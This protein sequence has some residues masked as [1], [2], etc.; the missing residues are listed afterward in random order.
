MA[1]LLT[2]LNAEGRLPS[3]SSLSSLSPHR[4]D[5]QDIYQSGPPH[6]YPNIGSALA[7]LPLAYP[8]MSGT[9]SLAA[10]PRHMCVFPQARDSCSCH[11]P[12]GWGAGSSGSPPGRPGGRGRRGPRTASRC[13][14][15]TASRICIWSPGSFHPSTSALAMPGTVERRPDGPPPSRSRH[16]RP[17]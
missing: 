1:A 16:Q 11:T 17:R 10:P 3:S 4:L 13:R 9:N 5:N 12:R 7:P 14:S 6:Q 2:W 15:G 8:P